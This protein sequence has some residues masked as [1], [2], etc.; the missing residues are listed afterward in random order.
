MN[1]VLEKAGLAHRPKEPLNT[2][3]IKTVLESQKIGFYEIWQKEPSAIPYQKYLYGSVEIGYPALLGFHFKD[4][5]DQTVGHIIP[6]IGHTF[7]ADTWVPHAE[8][9]YFTIGKDTR[10]VPSEAWVSTYV[11]HDDNFGSNFCI[12]RL[13]VG[14]RPGIEGIYALGTLPRTCKCD[15]IE[16]EAVAVDYLYSIV[17]TMRTVDNAWVNRLKEAVGRSWVVLRPV[18]MSGEKYARHLGKIRGWEKKD[19]KI[20]RGLISILNQRLKGDFWIVEVSFPELFPA[21]KRKLGEIVLRSDS[22][23]SP[24]RDFNSFVLARLPGSF[25]FRQKTTEGA[26]DFVDIPS[27]INTHTDIFTFHD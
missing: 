22:K 24:Q 10:Y 25:L 7:N 3:Q 8:S 15:P 1:R 27:G 16:A 21:N 26:I 18:L 14:P 11:C 12:P 19:E 4:P 2:E 5:S 6:V 13:Y 20:D 9:S 17:P 23:P